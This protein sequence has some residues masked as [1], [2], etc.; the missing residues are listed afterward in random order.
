VATRLDA[1]LGDVATLVGVTAPSSA[2]PGELVTLEW[3]FRAG[4]AGR[5]DHRVFV[6]LEGPGVF[7]TGDHDPVDGRLPTS[8]WPAG[9]HV[10]DL[11]AV[12]IPP[13][14]RGTLTVYAG[15]YRGETRVP[16]RGGQ[17][18]GRVLATTI[19]IGGPTP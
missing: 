7:I 17:P 5:A 10:R 18:D 1:E 15:L 16:V 19:R 4:K 8:R 6:H 12:R 11:H 2:R 9:R 14:A 13:S 3:V